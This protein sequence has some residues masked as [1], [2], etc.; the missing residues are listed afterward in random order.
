MRFSPSFLDEIRARLPV[1]QV[2]GRRV[3]LKRRGRE[4]V[5]LSPF[6]K[7]KTPSFTVNDQKGFYHCFSSGKHGDIFSFVMET[8]GLS[9]AEA[10]ERLAGEA[11]LQMPAPDPQAEKREKQRAGLYDIVEMA[12]TWFERQLQSQAGA[13]ARGYLARRGVSD[14]MVSRF[15]I[16]Y[17]PGGRAALKDYLAS[18]DVPVDDMVRAGLLISGEEIATPFDRFR[19]RLMFPISDLR[20]RIVAFGGRA[21]S[22]DAQAK[23]LNSPETPLF[24]KGDLLF[25]AHAARVAAHDRNTVIVAEGYLDVVALTA[26]GLENAVAPLGTALTENQLQI[27]WRM[28]DEPVLCFDGD[29]AGL[30]AAWRSIDVALPLLKP[31]KSLRFAL[32]PEG[33]DPD[34]ILRESG[35]EA[36]RATLEN[37]RGLADMLWGRESEAGPLDTPERRAAFEARLGA[38]VRQISDDTVRR[39]YGQDMRERLNALVTPQQGPRGGRRETRRDDYPRS[40]WRMP[41]G[42][43]QVQRASERLIRQIRARALPGREVALL[44]TAINHPSI[45]AERAE[46][47]AG[48]EFTAP[49]L[50]SVAHRMIDLAMEGAADDPGAVRAAIIHGG[51]EQLLAR[52][53]AA[54]AADWFSLPDADDSD[55][56]TGFDHMLALHRKH[57]TLNKELRLAES[58][59]RDDPSEVNWDRIVD[60][61]N[62]IAAAEG[63]EAEIEGFGAASRRPSRTL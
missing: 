56:L 58:A 13:A 41:D 38:A 1:S 34:D 39:Y 37:P 18:R 61:K 8:E 50:A 45:I 52:M 44:M 36:L 48:I 2:V 21:L 12:A 20:G 53:D 17:A 51:Q 42:R 16:G 28:V 25:N 47:L 57:V 27:L 63:S 59:F 54:A 14:R 6:N 60:L 22:A 33:R 29:R 43:R 32:M 49:E 30:K 26:A 15:R 10:V 62:A 4:H 40:G 23:Y 3:R 11:G 55:A 19:D 35:A 31:G 24:H 9:F 46:A 7:E 5:G